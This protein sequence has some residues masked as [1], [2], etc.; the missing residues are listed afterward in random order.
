MLAL[1][2][3]DAP[4]DV[5]TLSPGP[6][7]GPGDT[8]EDPVGV[9]LRWAGGVRGTDVLGAAAGLLGFARAVPNTGTESVADRLSLLA[10]AAARARLGGT[11][12][13]GA[14]HD[15]VHALA[16]GADAIGVGLTDLPV[17]GRPERA[18]ARVSRAQR[19]E[20]PL[21]YALDIERAL[22]AEGRGDRVGAFDAFA[23][24]LGRDAEGIE[25]LDGLK[26]LALSTGDR[27][28]AARAGARLGA[29]LRSPARAAA[30][31]ATAGQIWEDAGKAPEAGIAYWQA[32]ARE[33]GSE[34][35][36]ER[37]RQLLGARSDWAGLDRLYGHRLA[38]LVDVRARTELLSERAQHRLEKLG[39]RK[40]AIEDFKRILKIDPENMISLRN[41]A[42]LAVQLEY[43]PQA[44]R[45]LDRLLALESDETKAALLHLE[46][47][48]AYEASRDP[49][50]AV[51]VLR[52]AVSARP[53]DV[54]PWQRLTDLLLRMGDWSSALSVLRSWE[55][56]LADPVA[57]AE[58]WL[59]I[60]RLLRDHGRDGAAAAAA[61]VAA[62]DL[63]PLGE[64]IRELVTLHERAGA[65]GARR[66][67]IH[68]AIVGMRRD[69]MAD[70]LHVPRLRRLKDLYDLLVAGG[71]HSA[72]GDLGATGALV[73]RQM[74]ALCGEEVELPSV[75]RGALRGTLS[76]SFWSR[77]R[78]AGAGGFSAEIWPLLASAAGELFPPLRSRPPARER[79]APGTEARLAWIEEA[80]AAVG[81][82]TLE[83]SLPKTGT[84]T[85]D[86]ADLSAVP[87]EG[88]HPALMV[89]R[90]LL[91]GDAAARFRVGRT[92]GL[93]R[94]RAVIFD[95]ITAIEL[96]TF[97]ASA[98]VV[99]GAPAPVALGAVKGV[100]E[101]AKVLGKA[102]NRKDRKALE[103]EASRFG[104]EPI[105]AA[106]FRESILATADRLGLVLAGDVAV[107]V[108]VVGGLDVDSDTALPLTEI[109]ANK[110]ALE[111]I[112]FALSEDY[113]TLRR[114]TGAGEG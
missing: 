7:G 36:Y 37:L 91:A 43:F 84:A 61:F 98:A 93:L 70:P 10:R 108:R 46:L 44:V 75:H 107:A 54:A 100:E 72:P 42:T 69:L 50:R 1:L 113:L 68:H 77:L 48:E 41:L 82:P 12:L 25:A 2:N 33:P 103:L 31:F 53:R 5:T 40:A 52:R 73:T 55:S 102:M 90:G 19:N 81:L 105:D 67:A 34:W 13:A 111:L 14:V 24:A 38:T 16:A 112:R 18:A 21:A 78:L 56:V 89:G 110:R 22:D 71:D 51:E 8:S 86:A 28:G 4:V 45:F 47:A 74:L 20:G 32:L 3:G 23:R 30:E 62:S 59:R 104:F 109:A 17:A 65:L 29:V 101:R 39:D 114:D 83:L 57:K 66:D 95:R 96:G 6:G 106:F 11:S 99:A 80:A 76:S 79:V 35:L 64:G 58:I 9:V 87:I 49:V 26:R 88:I 63:D 27:L 60:G 97:L 15:Q 94:D 92:L 85:D